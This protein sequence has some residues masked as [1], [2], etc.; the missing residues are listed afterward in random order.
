MNLLVIS[1][2]RADYGLLEWPIKV[3]SEDSDYRVDVLKIWNLTPHAAMRES[4]LAVRNNAYDAVLLLGDR[5]EI[6]AAAMASHLARVPI[7]HIAGGDVTLG[8][9]DDAM[10]D[11]ISRMAKWHFTTSAAATERLKSLGYAKV[12]LVGSPGIDYIMHGKWRGERP[13]PQP[14]VVVSYQPETIDGTNEIALVLENLPSDKLPVIFMPNMDKG[15]EEIRHAVL[16]YAVE[17]GDAVIVESMPHDQF[18]NLLLHCD[19][20]IGNSS[21][22]LYEAPTL[23]IKTLMIGRRQEGRVI[24]FGDGKASER[25]RDILKK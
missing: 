4:A 5:F 9:Y 11:C 15:S 3:L 7:A 1:G 23:G 25:I 21:A 18:L 24:P 14:Y 19:K 6:M 16:S 8:S 22:I 10:R 17:R 13:Y 20:F 12:Y 2:S